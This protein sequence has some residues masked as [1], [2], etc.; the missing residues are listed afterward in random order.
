MAAK[1]ANSAFMKPLQ[2]SADLAKVTGEKPLPELP[3]VPTAAETVP[4]YV[5]VTWYAFLAPG[6][7]PRP[8]VDRLNQA[9]NRVLGEPAIRKIFEAQTITATGGSPERIGKIIRTDYER[10]A[11]VVK[12]NNIS[13]E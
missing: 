2:P 8:V 3:Q 9:V 6:G 11:K 10:W 13:I 7:T 12:E 5:V 1:K 4:G